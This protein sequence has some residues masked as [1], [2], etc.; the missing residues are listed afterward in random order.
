MHNRKEEFMKREKKQILIVGLGK[1]GMN[2]AKALS[3]YDCEV[4]AVDEASELVD[5]VAPYV[6][7]AAKLDA[8]DIGSLKKLGVSNFDIAVIGIGDNLEASIMIALTLKEL[9]MPYIIA[10][11]R[12]DIHTRLLTMIGVDKVIQPEQDMGIRIAKSI[13]HKSIIERIEFG[14]EYSVIEIKTPKEWVGNTLSKLNIRPKYNINIVCV[15]KENGKVIIPSANY[16]I[17]ENDNLMII[18]PN[19]ELEADGYLGKLL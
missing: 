12:D 2:V 17:E 7:Y 5:E 14:K 10:K 4:L 11:S 9:K 1:F 19:K 18:S 13:M 16:E 8:V 3:K 6:T 15:E